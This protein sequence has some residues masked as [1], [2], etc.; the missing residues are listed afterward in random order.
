MRSRA[1]GEPQG[2][3][4]LCSQ[5]RR[6]FS[7]Q[8]LRELQHKNIVKLQE[9]Y[10][11]PSSLILVCELATG[12]AP[13][14]LEPPP[15]PPA[16]RAPPAPPAPPTPHRATF[17]LTGLPRRA[18]QPSPG[19]RLSTGELMHR[20]AEEHAVYT[21]DEVKKHLLVMLDTMKYMHNQGAP[22][23]CRP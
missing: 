9:A 2:V 14:R 20:I 8:V 4:W 18:L 12:G 11:T 7:L 13:P 21:E 16:Q 6:A 19:S 1:A 15:A 5:Q 22:L 23:Q 3:R 10:E 17:R